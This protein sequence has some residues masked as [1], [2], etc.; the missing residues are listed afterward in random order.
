[1]AADG[2]RELNIVAQDTTYYGLDTDGRPRLAELLARLEE[3]AGIEWIRLMYLYPMHFSDELID[4]MAAS[5]QDPALSGPA[6]CSTSTTGCS[7]G[8][9]AA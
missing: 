3:V 1:M 5:P 9:P 7:S 2:V 6:A 4:R 8:W